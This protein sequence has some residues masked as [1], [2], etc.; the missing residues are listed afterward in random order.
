MKIVSLNIC[1]LVDLVKQQQIRQFVVENSV[2][3][4]FLQETNLNQINISNFSFK[5]SNY[6]LYNNLGEGRGSGVITVFANSFPSF[7]SHKV[8]YPGYISSF[9]F[10]TLQLN[11]K[12]TS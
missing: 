8:V 5:I 9:H 3:V 4:L 2:D 6:T 7:I 12:S 10:V 1:G 11:I